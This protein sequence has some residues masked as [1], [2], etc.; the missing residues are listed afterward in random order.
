MKAALIYE[1]MRRRPE[2]HQ[3]WLD[4]KFLFGSKDRQALTSWV[5]NYLPLSWQELKDLYPIA[6]DGVIKAMLSPWFVPPTGY[7]TFPD[8]S[9]P[10]QCEKITAKVLRLPEKNDPDQALAF[11][12][13]L[14][15]FADAGFIISVIDHKTSQSDAYALRALKKTLAKLPHTSRKADL[16]RVT[17]FH[18]PEDTT[19]EEKELLREKERQGT[20]TR[21]DI[22]ELWKK[23]PKP[24]TDLNAP[25]IVTESVYTV[26]MGKRKRGESFAEEKRFD[27]LKLF[28]EIADLDNGKIPKSDFVERIRL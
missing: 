6:A 7:S 9:T 11:L 21:Q 12:K 23:H 8:K 18:L 1:A 14:R 3:A 16:L 15:D 26:P 28:A 2:V 4:G 20:L 13:R 22:D 19:A 17:E 10:E 24:T 27:F 25:R 5:V